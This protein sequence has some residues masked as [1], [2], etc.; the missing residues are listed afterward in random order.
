MVN[1]D[2]NSNLSIIVAIAQNNAIGKDNDLISLMISFR[3][4]QIKV[5]LLSF[6]V[7]PE[8]LRVKHSYIT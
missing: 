5:L 7:P 8:K 6:R 1:L 3:F 2:G 4:C